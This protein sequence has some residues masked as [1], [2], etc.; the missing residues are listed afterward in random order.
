MKTPMLPIWV[1]CCKNQWGILFNPS[2]SLIKSY[3]AENKS[4]HAEF[5]NI[6]LLSGY[7]NWR[8]RLGSFDPLK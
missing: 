7:L 4:V 6:N 3:Q 2:K 1:I 8:A 5:Y